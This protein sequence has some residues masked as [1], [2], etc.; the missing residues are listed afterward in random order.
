MKKKKVLIVIIPILL[1]LAFLAYYVTLPAI[2]IHSKGFWGFLFLILI[3]AGIFFSGK[4]VRTLSQIRESKKAKVWVLLV[5]LAGICYL[6]G[7]FLSSPIVNAK[8]Y[9][10]LMTVEDREFTE[11]IQQ[12]SFDKIPILDKASAQLLGNRK[13]GTMVDMVSQYEV[14][15]FYTQINYQEKPVRVT[16]LK[17]ASFIKWFSNQAKGIPAYIKIDMTTQ[18]T[19]LV[20]LNKGI[21]YSSAEHLNRN[22]YRH[23]RFQYPTYIFDNL[24]FE[25][26]DDGT[27]YWICPVKKFNIGLF[28]GETIGRVVICNAITGETTDYK[29]DETPTWIDSVYSANMLV[30]LYDYNGSLKHGYL[31]SVLGQKDCLKTTEGY[32]YIALEDDVWVYTG[33]TSVSGDQSNVGFVLMNQRTMETRFYPVTGAEEFSAMDSAEGQVQHLGYKATFPLLLNI[34]NEP[35][36]FIALKDQAGLVKMYAMVNVQQYQNV[37]IGSTI[38]DCEE[39]YVALLKKSGITKEQEDRRE[40]QEI[41]GTLKK[42]APGVIDGNSHYYLLLEGTNEIFDVPLSDFTS[43]ISYEVG[44][45]ISLKYYEGSDT[46]LVTEILSK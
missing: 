35:T 32:N 39:S 45:K 31:N 20:K 33:V 41:E 42:I 34:S 23:L 8:K 46:N 3:L 37:A 13:M 9:Q 18:E 16:P 17:Y 44:D 1:V 7:W 25:I 21:R 6:V 36:Y 40:V 15:D 12:V 22:I 5:I 38:V 43:I 26:D 19:E 29:I 2:S 27:P 11:D 14:D 28:G 30:K 10:H 4:N 24:S